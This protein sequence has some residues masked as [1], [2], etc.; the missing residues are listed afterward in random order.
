MAILNDKRT[1][2]G[3]RRDFPVLQQSVQGK[4]VTFLDS[5]ASSQRAVPVLEAVR[6]FEETGYANIHRGSYWLSEETTRRYEEA[7]EQVAGFI[8]AEDAN[9]CVFTRGTTESIN[10]LAYTWGERNVREGDDLVLTV[11][12]H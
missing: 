1:L 6:E 5:G 7:R 2:E 4:P 8:G 12:E 10:L 3:A 9:C 11:M